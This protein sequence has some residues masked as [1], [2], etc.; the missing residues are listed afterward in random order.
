MD[1]SPT[2][3]YG[4]ETR[5]SGIWADLGQLPTE[6][7]GTLSRLLAAMGTEPTLTRA[8]REMLG[9]LGLEVGSQV[10]EAG[11]GTGAALA[12]VLPLV[13]SRGRVVGVDASGAFV[14]EAAERARRIG[15]AHV[16]YQEADV[17]SLPFTDGTF[18]AAFCDKL[19]VHV[20]TDIAALKE[21][22]RVTRPGGRIGAI[23][24]LPH[25]SLS[26]RRPP[27]EALINRA[28]RQAAP[29]F[30]AGPNLARTFRQAGLR[31]IRTHLYLAE[32]ESLSDHPFW[33]A[34]LIDQLQLFVYAQLLTPAEAGAFAEDIKALDRDGDFRAAFVI[35]TA[36]GTKDGPTE[37]SHSPETA[38]VSD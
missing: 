37:A 2:G 15:A 11:S 35:W 16:E 14:K 12:D 4:R 24:W 32:A 30:A 29:N 22:A 21:L 31:Q 13:G 34:C 9:G 23:E 7:V 8:R 17:R 18:D 5:Q 36:L 26:T 33:R 25:L 27:L 19:L 3:G 20:D 38:P 1:T 6:L 28:F 10:I